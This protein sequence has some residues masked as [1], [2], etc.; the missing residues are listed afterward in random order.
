MFNQNMNVK[1]N[2]N[3]PIYLL[4]YICITKSFNFEVNIM[5]QELENKSH[6]FQLV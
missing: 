4:T 6:L 5:L 3:Y 1:I 2:M